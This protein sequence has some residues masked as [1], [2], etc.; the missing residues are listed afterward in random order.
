[1]EILKFDL[2]KR[3]GKFKIMNAVNNGTAIFIIVRQ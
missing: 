1:M 2:E 3:S